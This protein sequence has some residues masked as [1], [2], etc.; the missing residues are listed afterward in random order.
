MRVRWARSLWAAE[1]TRVDEGLAVLA[2]RWVLDPR[3]KEVTLARPLAEVNWV[4][5]AW[6][7]RGLAA[8][9]Q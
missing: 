8:V 1:P 5:L 2:R 4:V 9:A 3:P 7:L 6:C